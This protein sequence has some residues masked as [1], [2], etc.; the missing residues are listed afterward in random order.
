MYF[1][2]SVLDLCV[3]LILWQ[4]P[5]LYIENEGCR[6]WGPDP[7]KICR[8][9]Q[10]IFWPPEVSHSFIQQCCKLHIMKDERLVSKM[11]GK[12]IFFRGAWNS[13]MVWPNWPRPSLAESIFYDR[14]IYATVQ[15]NCNSLCVYLLLCDSFVCIIQHF[16]AAKSS[17]PFYLFFGSHFQLTMFSAFVARFLCDNFLSA[18]RMIS[19]FF[20]PIFHLCLHKRLAS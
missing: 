2:K 8:R 12:T 5:Y 14:S 6:S 15:N 13:L 1:S 11:E 16:Y 18:S 4:W 7:L 3:S 9:G 19:L 17:K 20:H 10:S